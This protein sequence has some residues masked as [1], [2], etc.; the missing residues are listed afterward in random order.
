M[1]LGLAGGAMGAVSALRQIILERELARRQALVEQQ[2]QWENRF[3]TRGQDLLD[4]ERQDRINETRQMHAATAANL[5]RDDIRANREFIA[6]NT[7]L[8]QGA[9]IVGQLIGAGLGPSLK[10]QDERP[11]VDTGPLLSGDTGEEKK[12]GYLTLA[13]PGQTKESSAEADRKLQ[14]DLQAGR[15]AETARR[16]RETADYH[17]G[18]LNKPKDTT[19][20]DQNRLDRSYQ[21]HRSALDKLAKPIEDQQQRLG[22][23]IDTIN[24][25]TPQAD[26]LV[27][28]ELLTVMAGG[29]GSGLRMNEAEIQRI[30]G[31]RSRWQDLKASLQ[32]WSLD[33]KTAN[34]ITPEQRQQVRDLVNAVHEKSQK[35]L[36]AVNDAGDTLLNAEDVVTHRQVLSDTRKKMQQINDATDTTP[37]GPKPTAAELIKKYG[38]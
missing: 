19:T 23:L 14:R 9:P 3:K 11:R 1:G 20:N 34:S 15:D 8:P 38:G 5:E 2:Q 27:A 29:Q 12:Q 21:Y 32:K 16:D 17:Q 31:G 25:G 6:P 4:Q 33:P 37:A 18:V 35:L 22:R 13:T 28:P 26:A 7:F 36:G 30:V 24:S 10:P